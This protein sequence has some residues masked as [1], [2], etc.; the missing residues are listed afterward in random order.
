MNGVFS[1]DNKVFIFLGRLV[2]LFLLNIL[3]VIT[4]I[5]IITIGA[6]I[7]AMYDVTLRMVKDE[8]S[9]IMKGYLKAFRSNFKQSTIMWIG[10]L[11]LGVVLLCDMMITNANSGTVW[12]GL[13]IA[14]FATTIWLWIITAYIFPLQ[15]KFVN[16]C[17]NTL[18]NA[19]FMAVKHL[20]TTLAVVILNSVIIVCA[21]YNGYTLLYGFA[22]YT[23][24][25]F[26]VI[27]YLNSVM[28]VRV[29][30]QYYDNVIPEEDTELQEQ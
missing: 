5:P 12:T 29:F 28:L 10:V 24:I 30:E 7:T 14:A 22:A 13:H 17:K 4:C 26:A 15:A 6:A 18:R 3:F 1:M 20:P 2:D 16:T 23:M 21:I 8:E 27:A 19:C 25:G 11:I 9:Y